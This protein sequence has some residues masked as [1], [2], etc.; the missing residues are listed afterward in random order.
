MP[1]TYQYQHAKEYGSLDQSSWSAFNFWRPVFVPWGLTREQLLAK[2]SEF[3]K[4]FYLRPRLILRHAWRLLTQPNTTYQ[5]WSLV[6]DLARLAKERAS[7]RANSSRL[8]AT[9][10]S[11][12]P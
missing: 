10:G 12:L 1:G 7:L 2:H 6:K 9:V 4:R 11:P 3:L 5:I 8:P